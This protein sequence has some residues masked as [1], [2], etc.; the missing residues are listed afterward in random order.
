PAE[1]PIK[2]TVEIDDIHS[3]A[4]VVSGSLVSADG[5]SIP[6]NFRRTSQIVNPERQQ[7][8]YDPFNMGTPPQSDVVIGASTVCFVVDVGKGTGIE[9]YQRYCTTSDP[10]S[11]P[12]PTPTT[13]A[14]GLTARESLPLLALQTQTAT[15]APPAPGS[16]RAQ[17]PAQYAAMQT[18]IADTASHLSFVATGVADIE[19]DK[20]EIISTIEGATDIEKCATADANTRA[21]DCA[22]DII[23][24]PVTMDYFNKYYAPLK[25]RNTSASNTNDTTSIIVGVV[26]VLGPFEFTAGLPPTPTGTPPTPTDTPQVTTQTPPV[27]PSITIEP[28]DYVL[29][30]VFD[31]DDGSFYAAQISGVT[32]NGVNV[33]YTQIPAIPMKFVDPNDSPT[34][35]QPIA[36]ISGFCMYRW[37]CGEGYWYG[38]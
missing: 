4:E 14:G 29:R 19:I 1:E 8:K 24:A 22:S 7:S 18:M 36:V 21:K 31:K 3:T 27:P 34:D 20:N 25:N 16:I 10:T 26:R 9:D 38:R 12:T 17:Y 5:T 28:G 13:T 11:T 23:V 33:D 6:V 32:V 2:Y 35:Q 30:Y 37:C 15:P